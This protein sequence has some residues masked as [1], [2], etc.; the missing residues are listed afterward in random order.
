MPR[1]PGLQREKNTWFL[2]KRVPKD[3]R[4]VYGKNEIVRTLETTDYHEAV[5]RLH[6]E[7]HESDISF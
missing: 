7:Q 2:R 4:N 1:V 3:L 5:A 6:H